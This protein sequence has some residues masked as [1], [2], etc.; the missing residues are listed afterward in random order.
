M[1]QLFICLTKAQGVSKVRVKEIIANLL[2]KSMEGE[3]VEFTVEWENDTT[4]KYPCLGI[5]KQGGNTYNI[6]LTTEL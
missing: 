4:M 6:E 5:E 1:V 3:S 2:Q